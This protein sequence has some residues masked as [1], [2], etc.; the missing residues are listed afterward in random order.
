M[1]DRER[2]VARDWEGLANQSARQRFHVSSLA[3]QKKAPLS[4]FTVSALMESDHRKA[5]IAET[6]AVY[7]SCFGD[8]L[9]KP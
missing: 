8:E 9:C 1:K 2:G 5:W 4:A 7:D 3:S 6:E